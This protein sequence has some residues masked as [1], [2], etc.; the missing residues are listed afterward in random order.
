M[1]RLKRHLSCCTHPTSNGWNWK[2]DPNAYNYVVDTHAG[3]GLWMIDSKSTHRGI[4]IDLNGNQACIGV[5]VGIAM[6]GLPE[7]GAELP[8]RADYALYEAKD[9]G[10][11]T[12]RLFGETSTTP[13]IP[14]H[15][16]SRP[17]RFS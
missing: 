16:R 15:S 8:T 14:A 17:Q 12:F 3:S 11:N 10:R 2:Q 9:A 5:S 1:R 13:P 4:Y 6:A 7:D